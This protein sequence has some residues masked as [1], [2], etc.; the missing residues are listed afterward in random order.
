MPIRINKMTKLQGRTAI[1]T[2]ASGGMG[3]SHARRFVAAGAKVLLTDIRADA[4]AALVS[5]LGAQARFIG[6]SLHGNVATLIC[7]VY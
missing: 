1:I 4:G 3:A 5:E 2:G 7:S 6:K